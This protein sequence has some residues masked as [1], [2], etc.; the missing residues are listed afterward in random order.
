MILQPEL[1]FDAAS[2]TYT[3]DDKIVPSVSQVLRAGGGAAD[4]SAVPED[5]LKRAADIGIAVHKCVELYYAM[6]LAPETDDPSVEAYLPGFYDFVDDDLFEWQWSELLMYH[7]L[8][9]YAG[10]VDLVGLVEG[11]LSIIDVKTTNKIHKKSVE[12]QTAGYSELYRMV[13]GQEP[14]RRYILW[15]RRH[16]TYDLIE[17]DDPFAFSKF[18]NMLMAA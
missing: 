3:V 1:S 16:K 10:T 7:P 17:C 14:Y 9:W 11:E 15:L 18:H 5:I 2:H 13:S 12:L 8:Y 4:Y 6:N